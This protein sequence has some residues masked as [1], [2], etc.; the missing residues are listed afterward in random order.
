MTSLILCLLALSVESAL[1]GAWTLPAGKTWAKVTYFQQRADEWYTANAEFSGRLYDAGTRR[2]YRFGGEYESKAVFIEGFVGITDRLDLGAQI[3]YFDQKFS[4]DTRLEPGADAGF[5]DL[6]LLAKFRLTE[7]PAIVTLKTGVKL[8]T[9]EFRNEDGLIPVGEGQSDYDF[10]LQVGRSFWPLPIYA[11]AEVGYRVRTKNQQI[12]RDP[13]DE[14]LYNAEVGYNPTDRLLLALKVEAL[15]G[16]KGT[17]FGFIRSASLIKRITYISPTVSYHLA[18]GA[19][20]EVAVRSTIN[21]RNFPA[22]HQL[23]AGL[24]SGFDLVGALRSLTRQR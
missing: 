13:G 15:R 10:I 9:G 4:D 12:N 8:P 21:G 1:A 5:S 22:G 16:G 2:P 11:N 23:T 14:W 18:G 7:K 19:A 20:L 3:P 6:R 24:S 17:E